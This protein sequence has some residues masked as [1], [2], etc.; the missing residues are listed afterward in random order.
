MQF[1]FVFPGQG[2]QSVGMASELAADPDL[3]RTFEEASDAIDLDLWRLCQEGPDERLNLTE[4]T[5]PALLAAGV[6]TWRVWCRRGG[7][8][9]PVSA[10]HS[11]GEY[12]ALVAA[13]VLQ[14]PAATQLVRARGKFMQAAVPEG[15]GA[16]AAILGLK[17][18]KISEACAAAAGVVSPANLNAPGQIVIAGTSDAVIDAGERCKAAGAKRVV[19]LSVSVPSHCELMRPAAEELG[20]LLSE[21]TF[22]P[23][24]MAVLHNAD[25]AAYDDPKQIRET[26][27]RQLHQPVHWYEIIKTMRD[28]GVTLVVECG[29]GKVLSGMNRR[30]D[31]SLR[32]AVLHDSAS[33]DGLIQE[34]AADE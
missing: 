12:T 10:G 26:L 11:L 21:Q 32:S 4:N 34:L 33:I 19:P 18:D 9:P 16:M 6:A 15:A 13:G 7:K 5:Q 20:Q 27:M 28:D 24:T 8:L 14:L 3:R 25:V 23:P 30:I 31:R 22:S 29:P 1:S 2:S 17:L